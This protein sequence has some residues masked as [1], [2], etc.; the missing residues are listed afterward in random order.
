MGLL[1]QNPKVPYLLKVPSFSQVSKSFCEGRR[2]T[3]MQT[4]HTA[5][6]SAQQTLIIIQT[7]RS[8]S[9]Q[10]KAR[11]LT[12]SRPSQRHETLLISKSRATTATDLVPDLHISDVAGINR[13]RRMPECQNGLSP[14]LPCN[15]AWHGLGRF[16][17]GLNPTPYRLLCLL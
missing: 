1:E 15:W 9:I 2:V 14:A 3:R 8:V 13:G 11:Q 16:L 4:M 12:R 10:G 6:S 7:A 5:S 17:H